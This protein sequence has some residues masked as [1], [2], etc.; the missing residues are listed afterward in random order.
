VRVVADARDPKDVRR[1]EELEA[2]LAKAQRQ[3]AELK[4]VVAE[5]LERKRK[6]QRQAG[7]FAR[8]KGKRTRR[9]LGVL[10]ATRA[11]GRDAIPTQW[12]P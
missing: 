6:R 7:P 10:S 1:I 2:E 5:L 3:I 9:S 12:H 8:A 11:R 4:R